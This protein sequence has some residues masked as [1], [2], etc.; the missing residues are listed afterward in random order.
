[1][2]EIDLVEVVKRRLRI[3]RCPLFDSVISTP[4]SVLKKR[5]KRAKMSKL[6]ECEVGLHCLKSRKKSGGDKEVYL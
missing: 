3:L 5:G 4:F 2:E 6:I 1:M